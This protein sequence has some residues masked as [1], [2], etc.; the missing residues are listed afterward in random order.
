[1]MR[2]IGWLLSAVGVL[3]YPVLL[4]KDEAVYPVVRKFLRRIDG[5]FFP[6]QFAREFGTLHATMLVCVLIW[7]LRPGMRRNLPILFAVALAAPF[8][9]WLTQQSTS[10]LR[11]GQSEG[12]TVFE[13]PFQSLAPLWG[14][15]SPKQKA[16]SLPSGHATMAMTNATVLSA[17]MPPAA[18]VFYILAV[19]VASRRVIE[20]DHFPS[21]VF[22]GLL[23]GYAL[24]RYAIFIARRRGL[25]PMSG[26]FSPDANSADAHD[27]S[28]THGDT[29]A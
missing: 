26:S 25:W 29:N 5:N 8:T 12:K 16:V 4:V 3:V 23:L 18:P 7:I 28:N 1:M 13:H 10:R 24:T 15:A 11:P 17:L 9:C 20:G 21:D 2:R 19:L 22:L 6:T 14:G 27:T